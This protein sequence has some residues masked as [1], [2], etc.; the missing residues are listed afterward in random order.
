[1]TEES[2]GKMSRLDKG[3]NSEYRPSVENEMFPQQMMRGDQEK[4]NAGYNHLSKEVNVL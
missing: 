3:N 2:E 1:M 4:L